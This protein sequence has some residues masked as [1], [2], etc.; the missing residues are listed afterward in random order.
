MPKLFRGWRGE[1]TGKG[2]TRSILAKEIGGFSH[3]YLK[4]IFPLLFKNSFWTI[5]LIV[6]GYSVHPATTESCFSQHSQTTPIIDKWQLSN[7]ETLIYIVFIYCIKLRI[8]IPA[9]ISFFPWNVSSLKK[10]S[11]SRQTLVLISEVI[12]IIN[13]L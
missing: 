8:Q 5:W 11:I 9:L 13:K 7:L 4:W 10:E 1:K 12:R 3:S 2:N 6:W